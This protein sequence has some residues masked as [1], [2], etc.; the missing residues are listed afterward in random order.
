MPPTH[1]N[2]ALKAAGGDRRISEYIPNVSRVCAVEGGRNAEAAET[3]VEFWFEADIVD[4]MVPEQSRA[5]RV[6]CAEGRG[7]TARWLVFGGCSPTIPADV[8]ADR[9]S[10]EVEMP[11]GVRVHTEAGLE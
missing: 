5:L 9:I 4:H 8:R 3:S 6:T 11:G 10:V 7:V 2:I 1:V